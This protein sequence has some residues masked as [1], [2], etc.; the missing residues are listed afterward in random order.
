MN[1]PDRYTQFVLPEGESKVA[2]KADTKLEHAGTFTFRS[3]DHTIGNLLRMQL[4]RDPTVV[5]AGYRIPH[6]LEAKMVVKVQVRTSMCK[7]R[8]KQARGLSNVQDLQK[9]A[10]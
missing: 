9:A 4:H 1:Q 3:E 6:P 10:A 2:Y 8:T 5:F 7:T